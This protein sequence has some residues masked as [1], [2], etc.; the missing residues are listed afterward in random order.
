M[1]IRLVGGVGAAI[2]LAVVVMGVNCSRSEPREPTPTARQAP[3]IHR[4][5]PATGWAGTAYPIQATIHGSGFTETGNT[6]TFG[7]VEIPNRPASNGG[8]EI[9]F[10]VPKSIPSRSEAPPMVLRPG[11]YEVRVSNERGTSE[12]AT[13]TLTR[14]GQS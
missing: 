7:P 5:E 8:T 9:V 3:V 6:V 14:P 4:I 10:S 11:D 12:P 2:P 1:R 13:F